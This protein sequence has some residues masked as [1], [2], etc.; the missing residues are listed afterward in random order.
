MYENDQKVNDVS[1]IEDERQDDIIKNRI[2]FIS[3]VEKI[4][5]I[6]MNGLFLTIIDYQQIFMIIDV[7]MFQKFS[8]I[9]KLSLKMLEKIQSKPIKVIQREI[10]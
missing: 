2:P 4:G 9:M 1:I 7:S 8:F 3:L 10:N 6:Y 5:D